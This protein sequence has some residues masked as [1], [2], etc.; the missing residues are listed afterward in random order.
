MQCYDW[1]IAQYEAVNC[2][3][4]DFHVQLV[5]YVF[6]YL[7][8]RFI[9]AVNSVLFLPETNAD[10]QTLPFWIFRFDLCQ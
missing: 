3:I 4:S 5:K 6:Y 10:Y 7:L 1:A 9:Q 8:T 2:I